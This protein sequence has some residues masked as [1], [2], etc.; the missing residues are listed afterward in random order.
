MCRTRRETDRLERTF[1]LFYYLLVDHKETDNSV[2]NKECGC[3]CIVTV[4][5]LGHT[6]LGHN[7]IFS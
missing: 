6:L 4:D 3:I 5:E 7:V 1:G 2:I